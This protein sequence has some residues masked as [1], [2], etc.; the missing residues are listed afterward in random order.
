MIRPSAFDAPE[1]A[2]LLAGA[3]AYNSSLYGH[4]DASPI[5]P[6]EFTPEKRGIFL[7][8]VQDGHIVGCGGIRQAEPPAPNGAAEVKRMYVADGAR[9]RGIAQQILTALENE[10]RRFGYQQIILDVGGKQSAA[11][12]LYEKQG[13]HRIPGFTIYREKPGNRAYGK[14]L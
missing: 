7:L 6:A 8:A 3:D 13:Y 4:A 9:R 11:H 5:D 12:A 2:P 1:A 14:S 10:A